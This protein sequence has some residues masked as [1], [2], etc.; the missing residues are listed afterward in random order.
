MSIKGAGQELYVGKK[1]S[2][3]ITFWGNRI[4]IDYDDLKRIEFSYARTLEN[5]Y[6][7]FI[8]N[9]NRCIRFEFPRKVNPKIQ[10]FID[11]MQENVPD[12]NIVERGFENIKFYQRWWFS[13]IMMVCCFT[14]IG[15]FLMWRNRNFNCK[16]RIV[17]T[18]L[19]MVLFI[20]GTYQYV[21]TIN[22][23]SNMYNQGSRAITGGGYMPN[24]GPESVEGETQP[25]KTEA[26]TT[27]LITGHYT[28]G[29]D[30]PVGTYSFYIKSGTGNLYSS[31]GTLNVIFDHN[32]ESGGSI[33][34]DNFGT[35]ELKNIY[36]EKNII[37]TVT[38]SQE[39]SAGCD[40]GLVDSMES[41][42]QEGLKE[43]EVGYGNFGASDNIPAGTY[44]IEWIEGTGNI[45]CSSSA[46]TGIN[47]IMGE[48]SDSE[49]DRMYINKFR[50]LTLNEGDILEI[51]K[52]KVKLIPS[53]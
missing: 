4:K 35:E 7:K 16:G 6:I 12:L 27:T 37:V 47:E 2:N 18:L 44:D 50:N 9:D 52:I 11:L 33:G 20:S 28:V 25:Q 32:N 10:K 38:G 24:I 30:I 19:M 29:I 26:F 3:I 23:I 13:I 48:S 49:L 39:I 36:L 8:G 31:D 1:T 42:N 46:D 51:D 22:V 14:P 40:D 15:L 45:I 5:G 17:I 53:K 43:I 41:R 34:L 21:K